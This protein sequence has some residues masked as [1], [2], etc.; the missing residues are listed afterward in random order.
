[1]AS[2]RKPS[3]SDQRSNGDPLIPRG[4]MRGLAVCHRLFLPPFLCVHGNGESKRG[5]A[6]SRPPPCPRLPPPGSR[7]PVCGDSESDRKGQRK[8]DLS[9]AP[10]RSIEHGIGLVTEADALA[11]LAVSLRNRSGRVA[12]VAPRSER[13]AGPGGLGVFDW[14]WG[15]R[16]M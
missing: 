12:L 10:Q 16:L 3:P 1:M 5:N 8:W 13:S 6:S 15:R 11:S 14:A 7:N 2:H 4:R 9:R